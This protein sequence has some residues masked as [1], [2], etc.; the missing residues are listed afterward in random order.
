M[1]LALLAGEPLD[2]QNPPGDDDSLAFAGVLEAMGWAIDRCQGDDTEDNRW[3]LH[4]P[5]ERQLDRT[6]EVDCGSSGTALRFLTAS[7]SLTPGQWRVVGSEQLASRPIDDLVGALRCLGA[8]VVP[9]GAGSVPLR[10]AGGSWR[11]EQV[12]LDDPISSQYVSAL[13]MAATGSR[14]GLELEVRGL[15]SRPY[16]AVTLDWIRRFG[17]QTQ[18]EEAGGIATYRVAPG[19]RPPSQVTIERDWS[20]AAYPAAAAAL[21]GGEV[22]LQGLDSNSAQGDRG[23]LAVLAEMG[24]EVSWLPESEAPDG[25]QEGGWKVA[26][27]GSLR[28]IDIDLGNMPDQ[29]P[30]IAGV[31][32]FAEGETVI[33]G[34]PHLRAKESDRLAVLVRELT[35]VGARA[36]ETEDGLVIEGM[37]SGGEVATDPAVIDPEDDHRVAMAMAVLALRRPGLEM[38]NPLVVG[39]SYDDFWPMWGTTV[40]PSEAVER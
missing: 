19:L 20:S 29:V 14:R 2:I 21:T 16:V 11:D 37:W 33:R 39:K 9:E 10:L 28:G 30:T 18:V 34:V 7:L 25:D 35:R 1:N 23:L 38:Q 6:V 31:A 12:R 8:S 13:L 40:M 36:E 3:A 4:A 17:G 24:A 22:L 32:P 27:T 26:G 15:R 5:G